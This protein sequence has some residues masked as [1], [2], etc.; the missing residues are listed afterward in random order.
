MVHPD[1]RPGKLWLEQVANIFAVD[2]EDLRQATLWHHYPTLKMIDLRWMHDPY[3]HPLD[4]DGPWRTDLALRWCTRCLS[5]DMRDG[6][7]GLIRREWLLAFRNFCPKHAW[8]LQS[9]CAACGKHH[10]SFNFRDGDWMGPYCPCG[11][12]LTRSE[13]A[14]LR[15]EP[16][17]SG[18]WR[19]IADFE[20]S[21]EQVVV[22]KPNRAFA[23]GGVARRKFL[24]AYRDLFGMVFGP[25]YEGATNLLGIDW[26]ET[27]ALL[28]YQIHISERRGSCHPMMVA[29]QSLAVRISATIATLFDESDLLPNLLFQRSRTE[30]LGHLS[31]LFDLT[32]FLDLPRFRDRWPESLL[33]DIGSA[34]PQMALNMRV[35]KVFD[36]G[37][38]LSR[39]KRTGRIA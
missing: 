31:W 28:F 24:A 6:R 5:E 34:K 26:F 13:Y 21:V 2:P 18:A 37:E 8:P 36:W 14:A 35:K 10:N 30:L 15:A 12:P 16:I 38:A 32:E 4:G 25:A 22:R 39:Y 1:I 23:R 27:L 29:A 9:R 11:Y 33:A 17:A 19:L 20:I 3:H 7:P